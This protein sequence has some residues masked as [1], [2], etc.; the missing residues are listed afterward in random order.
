MSTTRDITSEDIRKAGWEPE[1]HTFHASTP[2]LLSWSEVL[3]WI[4]GRKDK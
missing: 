2:W 1:E 3:D 4:R